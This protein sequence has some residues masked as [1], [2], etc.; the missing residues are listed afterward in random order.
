M[1]PGPILAI[2]AGALVNVGVVL[3]VVYAMVIGA[4]SSR[5]PWKPVSESFALRPVLDMRTAPCAAGWIAGQDN[6]SCYQLDQATEVT[7]EKA[8][9]N[10]GPSG[11]WVI[12]V[13]LN[14]ADGREFTALT[15]KVHQLPQPRNQLA[16]VIG[17]KVISAPTVLE[18]I[19]GRVLEITGGFDKK[20]AE[21][22]AAR[23][24]GG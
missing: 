6:A 20:T 8:T 13:T 10:F 11:Q 12:Q 4:A 9:A 1:K 14:E 5:L 17:G 23:L 7:A 22:L 24:G 19:P 21:E 18:P 3:V 2:V 15:E 16:I